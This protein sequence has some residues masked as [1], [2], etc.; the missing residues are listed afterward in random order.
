M[1]GPGL[2]EVVVEDHHRR[3]AL[4]PGLD[5]KLRHVDGLVRAV[6]VVAKR[7]VD[8]AVHVH[9]VHRQPAAADAGAE[10][11]RLEPAVVVFLK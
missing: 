8:V 9:G 11:V 10:G 4:L 3:P 7:E 5:E 6:S 2:V 1:A